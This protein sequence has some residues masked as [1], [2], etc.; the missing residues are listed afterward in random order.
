MGQLNRLVGA[1][2]IPAAVDA[3]Q[4][5]DGIAELMCVP[6]RVIRAGFIAVADSHT[7]YVGLPQKV[8]HDAQ[9]LGADANEGNIDLVAWRNISRAAQHPA[10]G[11][12]KNQSPLRQ[13][14]PR[15]CAAKPSPLKSCKTEA[16]SSLSPLSAAHK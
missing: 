10:V 8:K 3:E 1:E 5:A 12:S 7:L 16:D 4:F 13:F 15:T 2:P 6:L 11:Q 9:T 14:A